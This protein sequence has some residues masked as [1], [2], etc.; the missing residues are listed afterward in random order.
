MLYGILVDLTDD[1]AQALQRLFA[2]ISMEMI[3]RSLYFF[4]KAHERGEADQLVPYLVDNAKLLG[5]I[6]RKPPTGKLAALSRLTN[7]TGA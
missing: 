4:V 2:A 6:K 1:V 7:P 5:L 3:Y